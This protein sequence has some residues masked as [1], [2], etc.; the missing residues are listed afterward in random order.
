MDLLFDKDDIRLDL[1][2]LRRTRIRICFA[3]N[4]E[5]VRNKR[6]LQLREYK[7]LIII[8]S[9]KYDHAK[10]EILKNNKGSFV[11]TINF[12]HTFPN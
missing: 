11:Y 9:R 1:T 7:F 2:Q 8:L 12:L 3:S 6:K 4:F 10:N 5:A